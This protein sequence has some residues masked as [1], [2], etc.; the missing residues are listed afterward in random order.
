MI[1]NPHPM[2]SQLIRWAR[3]RRRIDLIPRRG[4]FSQ[5]GGRKGEL[6]TSQPTILATSDARVSGI[7]RTALVL[8]AVTLLHPV[9][10]LDEWMEEWTAAAV[11]SFTVET[12]AEYADMATRHPSFFGRHV[13]GSP[14]RQTPPARL[15]VGAPA[16]VEQ[17]RTLVAQWFRPN[18]VDRALRIMACESGGDPNVMHDYSNPASASGLFQ[19]LGKYWAARSAAA[20]FAGVSIF[21]P[22]ANVATAAWLRDAAGWGSW[23]CR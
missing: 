8:V 6:R 13:H 16:G 15:N 19:H 22:T 7:R 17:W 11:D 18:E 23:V 9:D 10:A 12:L 2:S 20:G 14:G 5:G 4:A 21:D 1:Q 3:G